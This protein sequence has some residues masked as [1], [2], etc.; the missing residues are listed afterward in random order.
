MY[1]AMEATWMTAYNYHR[2]ADGGNRERAQVA[3]RIA[4]VIGEGGVKVPV[5]GK[6]YVVLRRNDDFQTPY[7]DPSDHDV[8][9]MRNAVEMYMYMA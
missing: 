7:Q 4:E 3:D 2:R 9:G 8:I 6:G 5:E 1:P